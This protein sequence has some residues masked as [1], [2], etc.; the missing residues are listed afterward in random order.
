MEILNLIYVLNWDKINNNNKIVGPCWRALFPFS[1]ASGIKH[2][3]NH[4][5]SKKI[6]VFILQKPTKPISSE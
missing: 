4:E 3:M 5:F 6:P 2:L 1:Y